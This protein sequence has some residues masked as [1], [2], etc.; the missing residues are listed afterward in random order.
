[1]RTSATV[2]A[3]RGDD[4]SPQNWSEARRKRAQELRQMGWKVGAIAEALGV[5]KGA[6]SQWLTRAE[7]QGPQAWQSRPRPGRPP[8]LAQEQFEMIPSMLSMGA[9]AWGFRGQLWTAARV[10]AILKWQFE[11]DYHK[12]HVTRLLRQLQWSPQKPIQ[13]AMQRDEEAIQRW[14][15]QDWPR[16]KKRPR[17]SDGKSSSSMNLGST[18]FPESC[19]PMRP[20]ETGPCS[21]RK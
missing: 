7:Q 20:G 19:G 1:M 4:P 14:R 6:V 21:D 9:E 12:D 2:G 3:M 11:V 8:K 17:N 18:C 13:R 15:E 5:T 10:A 16:L